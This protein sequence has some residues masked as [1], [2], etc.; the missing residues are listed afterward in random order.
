[1]KPYNPIIL[2]LD[3]NNLSEADDMLSKVRSQ[4]GMI[5][6][7][8]ELYTSVGKEAFSLAKQYCIPVFLDLK[9]HDTPTTVAKTTEGLM[10]SLA[11][12]PGEHFISIHCFGGRQMCK[13]AMEVTQGSNVKPVGI[14]ILTSFD[15]DNL[16]SLGFS[17]RRLGIKAVDMARLG[18]SCIEEGTRGR[19]AHPGYPGYPNYPPTPAVPATDPVGM[20]AFVCAPAQLALMRKH[21]EDKITLISPGIRMEGCDAHDHKNAKPAS[22][23]FRAGA[24]W[25]VVGRSITQAPDPLAAAVHYKTQADKY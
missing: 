6:I 9:L 23:A 24:N 15:E 16:G 17:N 1:M 19:P 22:F 25:I 12:L 3:Y 5:K 10:S 11:V 18:M 21:Y 2:A 4:V 7:G 8:L 14:T 20:D 13:A